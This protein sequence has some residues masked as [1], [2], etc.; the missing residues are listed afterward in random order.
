MRDHDQRPSTACQHPL[1]HAA[2]D[3]KRH[4][5]G[6]KHGE[7]V[8]AGLGGEALDQL[9]IGEL[10]HLRHAGDA[11]GRGIAASNFGCGGGEVAEAPVF[12][13]HETCR[14]AANEGVRHEDSQRGGLNREVGVRLSSQRHSVGERRGRLVGIRIPC[15]GEFRG[16]Y[17]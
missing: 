3:C 5:S 11:R 7:I 4:R 12:R 8:N 2:I 9:G 6:I 17:L 10:R 15:L 1:D 14:E 16:G 13:R